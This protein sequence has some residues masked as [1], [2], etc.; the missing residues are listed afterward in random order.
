MTTRNALA[1]S[2]RIDILQV[3]RVTTTTTTTTTIY[4]VPYDCRAGGL[5]DLDKTC[6]S[7]PYPYF[8]LRRL[9]LHVLD[10]EHHLHP[11]DMIPNPLQ[12]T[13]ERSEMSPGR[14]RG[15]GHCLLYVPTPSGIVCPQSPTPLPPEVKLPCHHRDAF[16]PNKR[17]DDMERD[18]DSRQGW[19]ACRLGVIARST[20]KVGPAPDGKDVTAQG[21]VNHDNADEHE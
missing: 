15:S 19:L 4:H 5:A 18:P 14:V 3:G 12:T 10:A 16:A 11:P 21:P 7:R 13:P 20:T 9:R 17:R 2:C 8:S 6:A 1:L